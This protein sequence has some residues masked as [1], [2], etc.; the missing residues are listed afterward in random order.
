[1]I[2]WQWVVIILGILA[3]LNFY[4]WCEIKRVE[5]LNDRMDIEIQQKALELELEKLRVSRQI[6]PPTK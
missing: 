1:M 3:T 5:A 6:T 4:H 2:A